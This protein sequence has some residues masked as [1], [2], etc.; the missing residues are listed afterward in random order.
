ML[1]HS[2][3]LKNRV[4]NF[5][6]YC[7]LHCIS[8]ICGLAPPSITMLGHRKRLLIINLSSGSCQCLCPQINIICFH[9]LFFWKGLNKLKY[10]SF[11]FMHIFCRLEWFW[12][13]SWLKSGLFKRRK[14][15]IYIFIC[16]YYIVT[17]K[18]LCFLLD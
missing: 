1:C 16:V 2:Q 9:Y 18:S 13:V 11:Y 12:N 14:Q 5:K 6:K 3:N 15:I 7:T 10:R 17:T 8:L 4:N